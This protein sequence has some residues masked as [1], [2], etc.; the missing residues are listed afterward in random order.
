MSMSQA[1]LASRSTTLRGAWA[2]RGFANIVIVAAAAILLALLLLGTKGVFRTEVQTSSIVFLAAS[3]SSIAG[4]AFSPLAGSMLFH[5]TNDSIHTV[6]IMLVASIARSKRTVSGCSG[7]A[8]SLAGSF[9]TSPGE[10]K[11]SCPV[12]CF[13][14]TPLFRCTC[15]RLAH[16]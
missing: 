14:C 10:C 11:R 1:E 7:R 13:C 15:S 3:V 2:V 6:Q 12:C 8:S 4:F 9:R 16:S 5:V